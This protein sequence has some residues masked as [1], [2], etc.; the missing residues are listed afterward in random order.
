M[1]PVRSAPDRTETGSPVPRHRH[2]TAADHGD[3][4]LELLESQPAR[5]PVAA[6][7]EVLG[8]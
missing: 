4:P 8:R 3:R 6:R 2:V 1:K 7:G 5:G